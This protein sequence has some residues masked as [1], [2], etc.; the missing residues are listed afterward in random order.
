MERNTLER[1]FTGKSFVIP[2]YQ[3]DY[4]WTTENIDDLLGDIAETVESKTTHYVGTF[5]LSKR[6]DPGSYSVV[7]GQQ[8]LT[9]L[10][11]IINAVAKLLPEK[12]RPIVGN[13]FIRDVTNGRWRLEPADYSRDFFTALLEGRDPSPGSKSQRLLQGAQ[14]YISERLSELDRTGDGAILRYLDGLKQLEVMEF[15]ESDE[16]KAIRMF[17]TVN[18]RGRPLAVV[19]KAKSLLIY[20]S[21]RFLSG[22]Y[23]AT[24]NHAFGNIFRNFDALKNIAEDQDTYISHISQG[25][26]TEDS[27]M[28]YHFISQYA[29]DLSGFFEGLL[30]LVERARAESRYYKLFCVLGLSTHLYPLAIRLQMRGMLDGPVAA[31]LTLAD[32]IEVVDVRVYKV[33]GTSPAKDISHLACDSAT[34]CGPAVAEGLAAIVSRFMDDGLF[35]SSLTRSIYGNGAL[36][37]ILSEYGEDWSVRQGVAAP[38]V[39]DMMSLARSEPTVEHVFAADEGFIFPGRGFQNEEEYLS[40]KDNLGNLSILEKSLNSRCQDR[41]PE[42]KLT[43]PSLFKQSRFAATRALVAEA[44]A[45]GGEFSAGVVAER[46][47]QIAAFAK[48]RWP[49]WVSKGPNTG[50]TKFST[51]SLN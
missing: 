48:K 1:F 9:T 42:Q 45:R 3:R 15:I 46:T 10:T 23:D 47:K 24:V 38:S 19:E 2:A 27:V 33:R 11:M 41:G 37:H 35:Q 32:L 26:F 4:A 28:R 17:Q 22:K 7:D 16:G 25:S 34:A 51:T 18:D 29:T 8:R 5:I 12:L 21:N 49:L 39:E 40:A 50:S 31:E 20:Y 14:K 43:D 44:A 13:T 30:K 36:R 6:D